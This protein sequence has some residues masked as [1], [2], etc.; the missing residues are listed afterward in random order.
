MNKRIVKKCTGIITLTALLVQCTAI[1]GVKAVSD[2][3]T[4]VFYCTEDVD[5]DGNDISATGTWKNGI[6]SKFDGIA[7]NNTEFIKSAV[8]YQAKSSTGGP[9][10]VGTTIKTYSYPSDW[11]ETTFSEEIGKA[12]VTDDMLIDESI[13]ENSINNSYYSV[14][15]TDYYKENCFDDFSVYVNMRS[16]CGT[17]ETWAHYLQTKLEVTYDTDGILEY[18]GNCESDNLKDFLLS[19]SKALDIEWYAFA[20]ENI[21]DEVCKAL[22]GKSFASTQEIKSACDT[23][24]DDKSI[25]K[26]YD[27][28]DTASAA[29]ENIT[30]KTSIENATYKITLPDVDI[31]SDMTTDVLLYLYITDTYNCNAC[32]LTVYDDKS[33]IGRGEYTGTK[34]TY[35]PID[36]T[37]WV[38]E[39]PEKKEISCATGGMILS[40]NTS[41]SNTPPYIT[42]KYNKQGILD[43]IN[44]AKN[45]D[46]LQNVFVLYGQALGFDKDYVIQNASAIGEYLFGETFATIE[47]FISK[48]SDVASLI[49]ESR[50]VALNSCKNAEDLYE[51]VEKN[52]EEL[53][54]DVHYYN[55]LDDK[56]TYLTELVDYYESIGDFCEAFSQYFTDA[57]ILNTSV[58]TADELESYLKEN[59]EELNIDTSKMDKLEYKNDFLVR[60]LN[61][62]PYSSIEQLVTLY[63]SMLDERV[64]TI[65]SIVPY[66]SVNVTSDTV[67]T[68]NSPKFGCRILKFNGKHLNEYIN[69]DFIE[70]INLKLTFVSASS[71]KNKNGSLYEV[72]NDWNEESSLS[73]LLSVRDDTSKTVGVYEDVSATSSVSLDITDYLKNNQLSDD[74]SL[75]TGEGLSDAYYA[76]NVNYANS[77]VIEIKA[78]IQSIIDAFNNADTEN[79][80]NLILTNGKILGIDVY[81]YKYLYD[82]SYVNSKVLENTYETKEELVSALNKAIKSQVITKTINASDDSGGI[83]NGFYYVSFGWTN[84]FPKYKFDISEIDKKYLSSVKGGFRRTNMDSTNAE[85]TYSLI[86][87]L[88]EDSNGSYSKRVYFGEDVYASKTDYAYA[89]ITEFYNNTKDSFIWIGVDSYKWSYAGSLA[90]KSS[91]KLM[92]VYDL[93]MIYNDM[94]NGGNT[95]TLL[96]EYAAGFGIYDI[97]NT[98]DI[99]SWI[100]SHKDA[101]YYEFIKYI[102]DTYPLMTCSVENGKEDVDVNEGL[103]LSFIKNL[104]VSTVNNENIIV[105]ENGEKADNYSVLISEDGKTVTIVFDKGMRYNTEYKVE[106]SQN[107]KFSGDSGSYDYSVF[108]FKTKQMD[109]EFNGLELYD[110][111]NKINDVSEC[112]SGTLS[113]KGKIKNNSIEQQQPVVAS[114]ILIEY[115][116]STNGIIERAENKKVFSGSLNLGDVISLNTVFEKVDSSKN[117]KLVCYI[118][119]D[120]KEMKT[121]F[122]ER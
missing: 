27:V 10:A 42:V 65:V 117:Y 84:T 49:E 90:K 87:C 113:I 2:D 39:N 66:E 103:S 17:K 13:T 115:S 100:S 111:K 114:I 4:K 16:W 63:N 118:W 61:K 122:E 37:K 110:G 86:S 104:D 31:Y 97:S 95:D 102:D 3:I 28:T 52:H 91:G 78:D 73:D 9:M 43:K 68:D 112:R 15:I 34:N 21:Q 120:F 14:D 40:F 23:V 106:C 99:A 18:I 105:Y 29:S 89:D 75:R 74:F 55:Q 30:K 44:N 46:E 47:D 67:Y 116:N 77:P 59:A 80:E 109:I 93:S 96:N 25:N 45:K 70:Q 79:I 72:S 7:G 36:I 6:L 11:H 62:K 56:I 119:N 98:P 5:Y 51:F 81:T 8:L 85:F 1:V 69:S 101:S 60:L 24:L 53:K 94:Q 107:L 58:D 57:L 83:S 88:G 71:L 54:L 50:L 48:A 22:S 35:Y 76:L 64:E 82:K 38:K 20:D 26:N 19:Y 121:L 33:I 32:D 41:K 92:A 12:V 108:N